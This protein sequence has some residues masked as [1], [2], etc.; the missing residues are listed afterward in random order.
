MRQ[1]KT[2]TRNQKIEISK[3]NPNIDLK[4]YRLVSETPDAFVLTDSVTNKET[5]VIKR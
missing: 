4:K 5:I 1:P 2:L 3:K